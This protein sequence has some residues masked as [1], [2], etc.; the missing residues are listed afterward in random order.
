MP[1]TPTP[2]PPETPT[3]VFGQFCRRYPED[4]AQR[5]L[6]HW[7]MLALTGGLTTLDPDYTNKLIAFYENLEE[8]ISAVYDLHAL[9]AEPNTTQEGGPHHA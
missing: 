7:F 8:V 4:E 3:D 5:R 9:P 2:A 1:D 6:W